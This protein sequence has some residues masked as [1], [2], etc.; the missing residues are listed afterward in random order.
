MLFESLGG[1]EL[2]CNADSD[3]RTEDIRNAMQ[4]FLAEH[5]QHAVDALADPECEASSV[6]VDMHQLIDHSHELAQL[7]L[8]SPTE[9]L[10]LFNQA[11]NRLVR[12]QQERL[13]LRQSRT[14]TRDEPSPHGTP[15]EGLAVVRIHGL[16]NMPEL[17][18]TR[19][20]GSADAGKLL[21]LTGTVIRAGAVKMME[22]HRRFAC[23]KCRGQFDVAAEIEQHGHIARPVRC[24]APGAE[25]CTSTSFAAV[26]GGRDQ[27]ACIDYQEIKVQEQAGRLALG[28]IPRAMVVLLEG[29]LVDVAKSG[30]LVTVTGVVLGRWRGVTLGERPDIA[31]AMRAS[32]LHVHTSA[33]ASAPSAGNVLSGDDQ[34]QH[35]WFADF[36][37][38]HRARQTPM[39]G[40]DRIVGAMCPR[41][42][43]LYWV[44]LAVLLVLLGGVACEGGGDD[45]GEGSGNGNGNGNGS[46]SSSTGGG[47][48]VRGE[49]HLLLVGDPGT[50]KS[51]FL[52]F[53][54]R[55][56]PRSVLTTGVGS[57]SAGLTVTAVRDG[58][59]WQLE[60]GALV[61]ADRGIC[62]IDEFGSVR[63][64]EKATV[65]EAME[66]QSIS[67]AKAGIVCR[68]NSRCAVLAA[69]NPRGGRYDPHSSLAINTALS[70]PLLSRFDLA[71]V[72]LDTQDP[73]WDERVADFLLDARP[74]DIRDG[75]DT[76]DA[77]DADDADHV[78]DTRGGSGAGAWGFERLQAYVLLAKARFRPH[79]TRA[80]QRV[81]TRYYQLQRQRDAMGAARTTIRLLESLIRLAQAHAKLMFRCDVRL[82]DAVTAVALMEVSMLGASILPPADALHSEFPDDPDGAYAVLQ[83]DVLSKLGLEG[84]QD[85]DDEDEDDR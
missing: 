85:D 78:G 34:Q 83:A 49:A 25:P 77:D 21:G 1:D 70:S 29:D 45:S 7:V 56:V 22:T 17:M 59:E 47:L 51:Q 16:P 36:W 10:A 39:R 11:L 58:G 66:Q 46:S 35:A 32:S 40:R 43:G 72:L 55:L 13:Q 75:A 82:C 53:A 44:K 67:V 2:L 26:E 31:L 27:A 4:L 84:L 37:R 63:E 5:C 14:E 74:A 24:L 41:V 28:T 19:V 60:A 52:K 79:A 65:L 12:A 15:H 30:D 42:Y 80:S 61:L 8:E 3:A 69:M 18:R 50:A 62:C 38:A 20:P 57:T 9:H 48:R 54:A 76:G 6:A 64:R 73:A 33:Q 68:L 81:L 23:T 71:M